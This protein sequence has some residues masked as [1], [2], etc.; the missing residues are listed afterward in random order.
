M[1]IRPFAAL[2]PLSKTTGRDLDEVL[3]P[4]VGGYFIA[5]EDV[6]NPWRDKRTSARHPNSVGDAEV[7]K[8]GVVIYVTTV[9]TRED[10]SSPWGEAPA[11]AYNGYD[12]YTRIQASTV[13]WLTDYHDKADR[14]WREVLVA[15]LRVAEPH[16]PTVTEIVDFEYNRIDSGHRV[17]EAL[18]AL[19]LKVTPDHVRLAIRA[20]EAQDDEEAAAYQIELKAKQAESE[21]RR[22]AR[23]AARA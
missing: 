13:S 12:R 10:R 20:C 17:L 23:D 1:T 3:R 14:A 8:A 18:A 2:P 7:V 11:L 9:R 15:M 22:A 16:D 21:A 6:A 5:T 4:L 19:G